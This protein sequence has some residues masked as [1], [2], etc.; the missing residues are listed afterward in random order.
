MENKLKDLGGVAT[1]VKPFRRKS[2]TDI[3]WPILKIAQHILFLDK[4]HN[5]C[6]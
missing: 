5:I 3:I 1:L 2:P 6:Y 4:S